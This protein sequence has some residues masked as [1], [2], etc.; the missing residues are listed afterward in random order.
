MWPFQPLG[1]PVCFMKSW[2][3]LEER[4]I[5]AERSRR[6]AAWR[7]RMKNREASQRFMDVIVAFIS[8]LIQDLNHHREVTVPSVAA[9]AIGSPLSD[10]WCRDIV[11]SSPMRNS[12]AW[13]LH[14]TWSTAEGGHRRPGLDPRG[15]PL[16][17]IQ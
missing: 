10:R 8:G 5:S 17:L 13:F 11:R 6:A 16:R 7:E 12:C 4:W 2:R 14:H 3:A 15:R 1:W 9:E